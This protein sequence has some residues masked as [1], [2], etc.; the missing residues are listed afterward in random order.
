MVGKFREFWGRQGRLSKIVLVVVAIGIAVFAIGELAG[1][2][3][4]EGT[5]V[6]VTETTT[7]GEPRDDPMSCLEDLGLSNVEQRDTD[8]W[9]GY[10]DSPFYQVGVALLPTEAEAR[11]GVA[12]ATD[13]YAAQGGAYLVTGPAKPSAGGQVTPDEAATAEQQVEAVAVCLGG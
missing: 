12:A 4:D 6:A 9:R 10:N 8:Y 2:S 1:G 13:V 11:Q 7:S 3:D 5:E